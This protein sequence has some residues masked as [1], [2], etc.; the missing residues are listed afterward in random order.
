MA[1][2]D[3]ADAAVVNSCTVTHVGEGKMRALVRR[4]AR[5]NPAIRT[6]VMGCAAA[7]DD[8]RIAE[9]PNVA[10]VVPGADDGAVARALALPDRDAPGA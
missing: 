2:P 1:A 6:V 9:L 7:V 3:G 5:N 8:G 4:L 10:A